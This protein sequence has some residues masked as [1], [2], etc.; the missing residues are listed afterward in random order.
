M[1]RLN[2]LFA[3]PL[4]EWVWPKPRP[5]PSE[6]NRSSGLSLSGSGNVGAAGPLALDAEAVGGGYPDPR[7]IFGLRTPKVGVRASW[8]EAAEPGQRSSCSGGGVWSRFAP[9][10]EDGTAVA[11]FED[12]RSEYSLPGRADDGGPE[13]VGVNWC[14]RC[15]C[16]CWELVPLT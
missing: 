16:C 11:S 15:C 5:R 4:N 14:C 7:V 13:S 6:P 2:P 8:D 1:R 12:V 3:S 9:G 10:P